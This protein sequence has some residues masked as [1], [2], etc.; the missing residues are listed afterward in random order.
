MSKQPLA[1][2]WV[3]RAHLGTGLVSIPR[4]EGF[5]QSKGAKPAYCVDTPP[6]PWAEHQLQESSVSFSG[7]QKAKNVKSVGQLVNPEPRIAADSD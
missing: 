2:L 4:W 1:K 5:V 3:R 7:R 6:S